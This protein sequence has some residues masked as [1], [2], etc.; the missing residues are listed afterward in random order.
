MTPEGKIVAYLKR[1]VKEAGGMARKV[2][3]QGR[4]GAA[5]WLVWFTFPQVAIVECKRP[6]KD[7]DWRS[8]QGREITRMGAAGWPIFIVDSEDAVDTMIAEVTGVI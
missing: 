2:V 1:R 7:V 5:D 3:F 8:P 6:G 4:R